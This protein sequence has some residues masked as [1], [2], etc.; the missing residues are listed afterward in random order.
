METAPKAV[1]LTVEVAATRPP[2]AHG[3]GWESAV[4]KAKTTA[5]AEAGAE[6]AMAAALPP[7]TAHTVALRV[8]ARAVRARQAW[9]PTRSIC[10]ARRW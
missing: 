4:A 6:R 1:A 3:R 2:V 9:T 7:A 10:D 5:E 8:T